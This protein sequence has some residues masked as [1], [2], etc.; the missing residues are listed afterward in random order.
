M[1]KG[2]SK[3][4]KF[5]RMSKKLLL[6][7]PEINHV[8]TS[9]STIKLQGRFFGSKL[10]KFKLEP[11]KGGKAIKLQAEKTSLKMDPETGE[12]S[13]QIYLN[14]KVL[15]GQYWLILDNKIGIGVDRE[16]NMPLIT[17]GPEPQE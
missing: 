3:G 15:N 2:K 8:E 4:V 10:P 5:E 6:V 14:P 12:S 11:V 16:G 7:P 13:V 1:V 17:V 9:G